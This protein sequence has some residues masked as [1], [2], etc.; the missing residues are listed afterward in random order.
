VLAADAVHHALVVAV[1]VDQA[2]GP[3]RRQ[4]GDL[5]VEG[6]RI[7]LVPARG[8][9][10]EQ[11]GA[12]EGLPARARNRRFRLLRAPVRPYKT[13]IARRFTV[14]NAKGA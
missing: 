14:G 9:R 1:P 10:L 11:R 4:R 8:H 5:E 6:A 12:A 2:V 7:D 3:H 13:A